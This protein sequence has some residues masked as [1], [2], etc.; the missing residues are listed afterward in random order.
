MASG[1]D[2]WKF[3]R[4]NPSMAAA[5]IFTV[6]FILTTSLHFYQ[7][8]RTRTWY[9]IPLVIGGAFEF[10]GYIGRALSSQESPD[11]TL[12]PYIMQTLLLLVAPAL[13]A[14]SIYMVL[15][16]I[17]LLVDGE[18]HSLIRKKWLTKI[19]VAGDILAFLTQGGGEC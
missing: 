18:K 5:V 7:L 19:F 11:W 15:G 3:Y 17:I 13:F 4:Y 10:L 2:T 8:I 16:R 1:D 9:F 6:L 14:A 12:G